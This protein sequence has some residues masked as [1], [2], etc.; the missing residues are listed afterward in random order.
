MMMNEELEAFLKKQFT[1]YSEDEHMSIARKEVFTDE[2][3]LNR[4]AYGDFLMFLTQEDEY[5][6][7]CL[8]IDLRKANEKSYAFGTL[9]LRKAFNELAKSFYIFRMQG[10]KFNILFNREEKERLVEILDKPSEYTAVYYGISDTFIHKDNHKEVE[11]MNLA[12][13]YMDK[14]EK[15]NKAVNKVSRS[16]GNLVGAKGNVPEEWQ[17]SANKKWKKTMW[18]KKFYLTEKEPVQGRELEITVFPTEFKSPPDFVNLIIV[19]YDRVNY[20]AYT[21]KEVMFGIDGVRF[22]ITGR[23]T[24]N[25]GG[26]L[27]VI[28]MKLNDGEKGAFSVRKE[29]WDGEYIPAHFG[30]HIGYETEIYPIRKS[31]AGTIDY[32]KYS[33]DKQLEVCSDGEDIE[34]DGKKYGLYENEDSFEL[35]EYEE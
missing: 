19:I 29:S 15:T 3:F 13:M 7:C 5:L 17:E 27:E 8:N 20:R 26:G 35:I 21:G 16:A 31:P 2:G 34:I 12:L 25:G 11:R 1:S 23:F 9:V 24:E 14:A 6:L 32:V 22:R 10:E 30:K 4:K 28:L 33:A 18:W